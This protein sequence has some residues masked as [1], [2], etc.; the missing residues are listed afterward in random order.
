M[1][2]L[3]RTCNIRHSIA[4]IVLIPYP[5]AST[6]N[7]KDILQ[8]SGLFLFD[9]FPKVLLDSAQGTCTWGGITTYTYM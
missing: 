6:S 9:L 7:S 5:Q 8:H 1:Q 3:Q 4:V 2:V